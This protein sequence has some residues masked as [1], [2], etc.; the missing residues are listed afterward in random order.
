MWAGGWEP[1]KPQPG[2]ASEIKNTA[3]H[4]GRR[5][6]VLMTGLEPVRRSKGF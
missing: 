2:C 3:T 5:R 4:R 6:M 1:E